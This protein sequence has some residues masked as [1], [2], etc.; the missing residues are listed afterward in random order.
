MTDVYGTDEFLLK[1]DFFRNF[2]LSATKFASM[3]ITLLGGVALNN[4]GI[5]WNSGTE[6]FDIS[7]NVIRK[8]TENGK[9][10]IYVYL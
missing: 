6:K 2:Y 4:K 3:E 10:H 1:V 9:V 8:G 7:R 5:T